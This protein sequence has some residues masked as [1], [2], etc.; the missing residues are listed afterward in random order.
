MTREVWAPNGWR[1]ESHSLSPADAQVLMR[2]WRT[3][4]EP[5]ARLNQQAFA[6]GGLGAIRLS[7]RPEHLLFRRG[8]EGKSWG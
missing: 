4:I 5:S 8:G 2:L 6:C 7:P 3:G 1:H